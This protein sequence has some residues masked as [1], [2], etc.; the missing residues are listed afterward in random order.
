MLQTENLVKKSETRL[1]TANGEIKD[2]N[3]IKQ[4]IKNESSFVISDHY[5]AD[6]SSLFFSSNDAATIGGNISYSVVKDGDLILFYSPKTVLTNNQL[7]DQIFKYRA[8]IS[9]IPTQNGYN[10]ITQEVRVARGDYDRF[11][12]SRTVFLLKHG[13]TSK[14]SGIAFNDIAD[15]IVSKLTAQDTLAYLETALIMAR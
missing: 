8:P 10:Y 12:F 15:D 5:V 3:I 2:Q 9:P 1:F 7:V 4:F 6:G 14:Q 13:T 11:S